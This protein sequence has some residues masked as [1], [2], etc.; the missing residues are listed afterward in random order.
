MKLAFERASRD[1]RLIIVRSDFATDATAVAPVLHAA[2]DGWQQVEAPLKRLAD[3]LEAGRVSEHAFSPEQCSA[4]LPRD[5]QWIDGSA[6]APP[7]WNGR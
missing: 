3:E 7:E 2:L 6:L 5:C 4:P 1:G